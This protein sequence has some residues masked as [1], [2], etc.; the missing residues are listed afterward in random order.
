MLP[1]DATDSTR[2]TVATLESTCA[3]SR[4]DSRDSALPPVPA[5]LR[6]NAGAAGDVELRCV[7]AVLESVIAAGRGAARFVSTGAGAARRLAS[8]NVRIGFA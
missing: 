8:D 3:T 7:A 5:R 2:G 6:G 4:R 1:R